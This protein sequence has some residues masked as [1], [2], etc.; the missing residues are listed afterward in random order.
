MF[1]FDEV[2]IDRLVLHKVGNKH[3]GTGV[4][5]S[6]AYTPLDEALEDLLHGYFLQH[7]KSDEVFHFVHHAGVAMHELYQYCK[8]AFEDREALLEVSEHMLHYLYEASDHPKIK[9]GELYV[10]Y[11]EQVLVEDEI[12]DAIG[13]FKSENRETFMNFSLEDDRYRIATREGVPTRKLDKGAIIF[14]AYEEDGYRVITTDMSGSDAR[15]WKE[16]FLGI[17]NVPD[18]SYHTKTYLNLCKDFV[19]KVVAKEEDQK[20][21]AK[22]INKSIEYFETHDTFDYQDFQEQVI[23]RPEYVEQFDAFKADYAEKK[24]IAAEDDFVIARSTVDKMKKK[25][26]HLIKLDTKVEI[27][28]NPNPEM[29]NAAEEYIEKGFDESKGMYFYKIYY[30]A[31]S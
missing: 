28:V 27:K 13:I 23:E 31:E 5:A 6:K 9:S 14:G 21:Q 2:Q 1:S 12:V 20:E 10:A 8:A 26:K 3:E 17:D 16:A 4:T 24:G 29:P 19:K 25:F 7:F 30:N 15:Y 22:I 11:F 18:N